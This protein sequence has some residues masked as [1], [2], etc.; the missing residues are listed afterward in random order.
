MNSPAEVLT[1]FMSH[2]RARV[3]GVGE[4]EHRDAADDADLVAAT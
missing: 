1:T 4:I 3:F 2:V